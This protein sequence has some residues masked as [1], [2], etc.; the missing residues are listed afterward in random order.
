[1]CAPDRIDMPTT[2][3]SSCS[4]A[5]AIISGVWRSPV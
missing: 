1:M 4:A 5:S 3:T 2:S